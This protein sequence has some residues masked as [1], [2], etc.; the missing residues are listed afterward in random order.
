MLLTEIYE[1]QANVHQFEIP[2]HIRTSEDT[3]EIINWMTTVVQEIL[4]GT[5]KSAVPNWLRDGLQAELREALMPIHL[6]TSLRL[7][8]RQQQAPIIKS[9]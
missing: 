1:R 2:Q 4:A 8:E 5:R 3:V 9:S 6:R 7:A